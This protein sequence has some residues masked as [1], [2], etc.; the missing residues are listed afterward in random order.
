MRVDPVSVI[1]N[2]YP[3]LGWFRRVVLRWVS[4]HLAHA[5]RNV[6]AYHVDVVNVPVYRHGQ[7]PPMPPQQQGPATRLVERAFSGSR[8]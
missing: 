4:P 3:H 1:A 5:C 7:T 6:S 2:E 8:H